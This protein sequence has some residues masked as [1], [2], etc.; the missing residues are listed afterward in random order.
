MRVGGLWRYPVKSLGGEPVAEVELDERGIVDDRRWA[1]L[2]PEGGIA[3]GKTT[4]RFRRVPGLLL[5]SAFLDGGGTPVVRLA[6]GRELAPSDELAEE[7]AGPGWRFGVE[8]AVS[9]FDVG[10]VHV[11]TTAT[12]RSLAEAA[13][14]PVEPERLRPGI[15]VEGE[16]REEAWL[17]RRLRVGEVELEVTERAERCVMVGLEQRELVKRP[18]LL[19][20]IGAWNDLDAGVYA[21]VRS[22]GRIRVGDSVEVAG[23]PTG[24]TV[25]A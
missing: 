7:L 18:R 1:L 11:V 19:K 5:H 6:D 21:D 23:R 9:H 22:P 14:H 24:A 17:G 15:L 4:R 3:S 25:A 2:D 8:S 20:T 16:E 12:L 10:P 13:G